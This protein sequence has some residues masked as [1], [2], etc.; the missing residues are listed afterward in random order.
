MKKAECLEL[1]HMFED[2]DFVEK[3]DQHV[4]NSKQGVI[5]SAHPCTFY[6]H[7]AEQSPGFNFPPR[8]SRFLWEQL[9]IYKETNK[10]VL[11]NLTI[12]DKTL[13]PEEPEQPTNPDENENPDESGGSDNSGDSEGTG[14]PD[15]ADD[16]KENTED[17][18][19]SD[20]EE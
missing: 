15:D 12:I 20:T 19:Q 9:M 4:S 10:E 7:Q 18:P 14:E 5:F 16:S 6:P 11:E 8:I 3:L 17:D 1:S 13:L 2:I